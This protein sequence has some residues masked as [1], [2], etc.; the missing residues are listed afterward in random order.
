[1]DEIMAKD[2]AHQMFKQTKQRME[3]NKK[4]TLK[5]GILT[6]LVIHNQNHPILPKVLCS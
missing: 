2:T 5:F 3:A 4:V 6:K 1:M